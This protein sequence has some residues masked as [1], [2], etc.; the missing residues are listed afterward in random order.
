MTE[1]AITRI[2]DDKRHSQ[3]S[4]K[5]RFG[6]LAADIVH[7]IFRL[8]LQLDRIHDYDV[9]FEV[10]RELRKQVFRL[11]CVS[12]PWNEFILFSPQYWCVIDVQAPQA[13]MV[14]TIERAQTAPLCV[15]GTRLD[16]TAVYYFDQ[17]QPMLMARRNQIRTVRLNDPAL[18]RFGL[19]LIR[20]GLPILKTLAV[21]PHFD[22]HRS[23]QP[24]TYDMPELC[25]LSSSSWRPPPGAVW[26]RSLKT[27][28]LRRLEGSDSD[29]Y[30]ILNQCAHGLRK[31]SLELGSSWR[32]L[33]NARSAI[34]MPLMEEFRLDIRCSNAP[35]E[36]LRKILIPQSA[37]GIIRVSGF[38]E[39]VT[40]FQS[41]L[42]FLVPAER[43]AVN[44]ESAIVET[45]AEDLLIW[46]KYTNGNRTLLIEIPYTTQE[47]D[48][49]VIRQILQPV[50][51]R[52]RN[53]A[54]SATI[55]INEVSDVNVLRVLH[56]S[57]VQSLT[58]APFYLPDMADLVTATIG[59][60][61]SNHLGEADA[62][63]GDW[64][65]QS[66]R[67]FAIDCDNLDVDISGVVR[68]ITTRQEYM[69]AHGGVCLEEVVISH[70]DLPGMAFSD[71]AEKLGVVGIIAREEQSPGLRF[72][73]F[74]FSRH[75]VT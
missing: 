10:L 21:V 42:D 44:R 67:Y 28:V 56:T 29:L 8:V 57:N 30:G 66:L 15:Y 46:A 62:A 12:T 24:L 14:K 4:G 47:A 20:P 51:L 7:S 75:I 39:D 64:P 1:T 63:A 22:K 26:I 43:S 18:Y 65:L 9:P 35:V 25:H 13:T 3:E 32:G 45:S 60:H 6:Q 59:L 58:V 68:V 34:V 17:I 37:G 27:L 74:E 40:I 50:H 72:T 31:L 71:A 38:L 54:I 70:R 5:L 19:S 53:L 52:L 73:N 69:Q 55:F 16:W 33:P 2:P 11:R 36:L 41:L 49:E 61:D 23:E 48:Y